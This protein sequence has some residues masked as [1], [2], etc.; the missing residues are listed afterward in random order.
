MRGCWSIVALI[1]FVMQQFV[2]C[3]ATCASGPVTTVE[4][5]SPVKTCC[6]HHHHAPK[7]PAEPESSHHLCVATHLFFIER[8]ADAEFDHFGGPLLTADRPV[9]LLSAIVQREPSLC[10]SIGVEARPPS[11]HS[12]RALLGVWTL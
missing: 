12:R 2:C 9:C 7:Q 1:G 11:A 10:G 8:V 5:T 6:G 3:A 4:Q